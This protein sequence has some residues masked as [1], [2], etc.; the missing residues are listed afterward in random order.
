[1]VVNDTNVLFFLELIASVAFVFCMNNNS[2][3]PGYSIDGFVPN[4]RTR[5]VGTTPSSNMR[6]VPQRRPGFHVQ[7]SVAAQ[8]S[9]GS[10]P[11]PQLTSRGFSS[12]PS[13]T[14]APE[15]IGRRR[16]SR[17]E[18][19]RNAKHTKKGHSRFKKTVKRTSLVMGLLVLVIVG[20]LGWKVF[21][22][23]SK[24]FGSGSNLLG[25]LSSTPLS[26]ESSG[27]CNFLMAGYSVDDPNNT[28]GA[29]TDSIMIVSL[30]T[31]D[32]TAFMMSV[33]R[34]FYVNVPGHGYAK[35]NE[36]Y[37][38]GENDHFSESGYAQGGMGLLEK[39]VSQ[40]FGMPIN[41]YVLVD[42]AALKQA[43]D[44][45]G[46]V[47]INIQS[48]D[49]RGIYDAYT[50]LKLPNG[51]DTLDGQQALNLARARGD[52][53]AGDVSYGLGS[54]FI[55]T[56][57]QRQIIVAI[58]DK[59]LSSGVIANPIK[60]GELFDAFGNNIHTD[61]TTS[62]IRRLYDLSK[63]INSSNIQSY[64][65]NSVTFQ[66]HT[67]VDLL[68]NYITPTAEEALVPATGIGDYT[69]IQQFIKMISTNDPSAREAADIV[70]LNGGNT[71][72]LAA[73]ESNVL[74]NKGL[75]VGAT[76][77]APATQANNTIIDNSAGKDPATLS[78]L[79]GLFGGSTTTN[80]TLSATYPNANFII[81]L[82]SNQRLP[83]GASPSNP[84]PISQ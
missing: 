4:A 42:N 49:P 68:A 20:Y 83:A 6:G 12:T 62:N 1:M 80:A 25:F 34:D 78:E 22:A 57:H 29:L 60:L 58:K 82:G 72:G 30:D 55:R 75:I 39:T 65:L 10:L 47:T 28:G 73:A 76:G 48:S 41:N 24:V 37:E 44:A 5:H 74:K 14:N 40:T 56:Q 52:D 3:R 21:N 17:Q 59:A 53:V 36:T 11:A 23:T 46:G 32:H 67:N 43:V 8:P 81:I 31:K 61:L 26:C 69:Q 9:R 27:R 2:R 16:P 84:T 54:D 77:D 51:E 70:I 38:D 19:A 64:G 63:N 50:H 18:T 45:V 35:I 33:P 66:G 7:P 13:V 15:P 71:S 79:K